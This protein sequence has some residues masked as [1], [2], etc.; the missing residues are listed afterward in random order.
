MKAVFRAR[1]FQYLSENIRKFFSLLLVSLN[2][3]FFFLPYLD[4]M[5]P[6]GIKKK[7]Y[8]KKNPVG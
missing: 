1:Y 6:L 5:E 3:L 8:F 2:V 7:I 4:Q